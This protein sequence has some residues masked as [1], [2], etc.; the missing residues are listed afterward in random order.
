MRYLVLIRRT[1]TGYSV[2]VPDL[3]GCVAA[4]KTIEGARRRIR[5]ALTLH[6]DLM[7]Q[8]GENIPPPTKRIEFAIDD[9]SEEELC[10]W[11]DVETSGQLAAQGER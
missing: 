8:A 3:P 6:L 11:V 5:K 1:A 7:F 10:T 2:D 9:N 4:A